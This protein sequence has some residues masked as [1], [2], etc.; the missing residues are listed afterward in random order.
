MLSVN[1]S[2]KVKVDL[3][4]YNSDFGFTNK[5]ARVLWN[6]FYW[7]LF[8]PFNLNL[9]NSW[10]AVVLR[11]FG[12]KVGYKANIYASVKIWAPWNLSI[13]DYSSLGP[14]VD[15]YNQG[16]IFIGDNTVISQKSYLCASTHDFTISNFPLIL[17]PIYI[18]DQ[19]WIAADAFV[20][21]G[22]TIK[23]GSVVGA[24][25]AVFKDVEAW[26]V[27]GGNPAN[28]IKRREIFSSDQ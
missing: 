15:C 20:A 17:K 5:I 4:S 22:V 6:L 26:S 23:K 11:T 3:S 13:G 2:E 1:S 12:A 14:G 28:Y 25:S 16:K 9:F 27:V 8:R 21:P 7:I 10:R 19:V 18:E 24:R